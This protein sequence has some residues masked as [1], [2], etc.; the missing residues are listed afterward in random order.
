MGDE[1]QLENPFNDLDTASEAQLTRMITNLDGWNARPDMQE[2]KRVMLNLLRLKPGDVV[3]DAGCGLGDDTRSYASIVGPEGKATGV[4]VT[5]S[6]IEVARARNSDVDLLPEFLVADLRTL[7]VEDNTYDAIRSE[8]VFEW[9]D[10]PT[11]ALDE[12]IRVLKPGGRIV[13]GSTDWGTVS[14]GVGYPEKLDVI[15]RAHVSSVP[16]AR[17]ARM[18][19]T[20]FRDR[21]LVDI[22]VHPVMEHIDSATHQ[23]RNMVFDQ[24]DGYRDSGVITAE[25][26][27]EMKEGAQYAMDTNSAFQFCIL[28]ITAGT[29]PVNLS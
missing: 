9:M 25:Q 5:E 7:P 20:R 1:Q 3:L 6:L 10:N 27:E 14:Y 4:D 24:L 23:E 17:E 28:I 13:I 19:P 8:R 18:I 12:L 29:K 26:A 22:S 15:A 16:S 11:Q 21:G 2:A